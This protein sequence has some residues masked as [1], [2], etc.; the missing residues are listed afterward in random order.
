MAFKTDKHLG[1]N[2][3]TAVLYSI[4]VV[5]VLYFAGPRPAI[6]GD[7]QARILAAELLIVRADLSRLHG[8]TPLPPAHVRGLNDR[9]KGAL[10]V[11]PW[12]LR[13]AD[14]P[15]GADQL[16][17][18]AKDSLIVTLARLIKRHPLDL[19][20]YNPAH[21]S[22]SQRRESFAIHDA[23]CANCHDDAGPGDT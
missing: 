3:A 7:P 9:I 14:D 21:L 18:T 12:L 11:L 2:S 15:T 20:A 19:T 8:D 16:V 6:S 10:G 13:Q 4:A 17:S 23:Y 5:V 22:A 1:S